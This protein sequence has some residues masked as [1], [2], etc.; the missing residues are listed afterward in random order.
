MLDRLLVVVD[1]VLVVEALESHLL[2]FLQS[3]LLEFQ[4]LDLV[5]LLQKLALNAVDLL[6]LLHSTW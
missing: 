2:L 5:L 1:V 3:F 4:L 6:P